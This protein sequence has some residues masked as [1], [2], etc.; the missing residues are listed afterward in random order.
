MRNLLEYVPTLSRK[1]DQ[2]D[3]THVQK[4]AIFRRDK[5]ICQLKLK[6]DGIKL[7]WDDWHC[8]HI[9]P[10]SKGGHTTVE[11]GQVTCSACNLSKGAG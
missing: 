1:D 5:G 2:R 7:T 6:C 8:D 4:L 9:I 10:W 3:F 11:N